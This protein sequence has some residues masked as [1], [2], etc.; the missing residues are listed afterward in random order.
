M[1]FAS[2]IYMDIHGYTMDILG[3][4][5]YLF[6]FFRALLFPAPACLLASPVEP[7]GFEACRVF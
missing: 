5:V 4:T 7:P 3:Y 1:N 2:W 6:R